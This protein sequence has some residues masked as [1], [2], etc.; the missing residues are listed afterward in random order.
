MARHK[1]DSEEIDS[2]KR[3]IKKKMKK[4]KEKSFLSK[5]RKQNFNESTLEEIPQRQDDEYYRSH[6]Y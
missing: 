3:L 1:V 5:R 6:D 2:F 4:I